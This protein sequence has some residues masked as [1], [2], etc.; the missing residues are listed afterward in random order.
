MKLPYLAPKA[1]RALCSPSAR[2]DI[3]SPEEPSV[4]LYWPEHKGPNALDWAYL[5]G[6]QRL[7]ETWRDNMD[8]TYGRQV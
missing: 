6:L 8:F 3:I 4:T 2:K 7:V 5:Y 1:F